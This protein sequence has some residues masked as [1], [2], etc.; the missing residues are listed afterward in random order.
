[1][2]MD[3][4][5]VILT[6]GRTSHSVKTINKLLQASFITPKKR[7]YHTDVIST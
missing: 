7:R 6:D 1:M 4:F 2:A 3:D 5:L